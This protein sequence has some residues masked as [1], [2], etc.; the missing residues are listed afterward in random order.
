MQINE[1]KSGGNRKEM[2]A[3]ANLT[4]YVTCFIYT[5]PSAWP[6]TLKRK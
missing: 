3:H 5:I 2:S 6:R 1:D 4:V